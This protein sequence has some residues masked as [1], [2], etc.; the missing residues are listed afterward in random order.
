MQLI[1]AGQSEADIR[2][3][4]Y[5]LWENAGRPD[6]QAER[7]W[8]LALSLT[9]PAPAAKAPAKKRAPAAKARRAA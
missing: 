2:Q 3:A 6:G 1:Q 7:H 9:E 4:A 5:L 8:E